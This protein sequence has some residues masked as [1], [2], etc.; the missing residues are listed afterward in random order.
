MEI[1]VAVNFLEY[2]PKKLNF[3][4]LLRYFGL[5][6]GNQPKLNVHKA[7]MQLP[8]FLTNIQFSSCNQQFVML[9]ILGQR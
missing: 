8:E 9:P 4:K 2:F 6:V 7:I 5:Q 3:L 1:F